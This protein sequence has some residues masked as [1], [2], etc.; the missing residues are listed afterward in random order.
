[1]KISFIFLL[2][3]INAFNIEP[4]ESEEELVR[5]KRIAPALVA[6]G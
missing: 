1:M 3:L 4:I 2:G 5:S 6:A